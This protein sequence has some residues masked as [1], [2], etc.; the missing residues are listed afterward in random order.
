M[1][2]WHPPVFEAKRPYLQARMAIIKAIRG[3]F[4]QQGLWEVETPALQTSPT[5]DT[6]IHA[7]KTE[8]LN[9]N[10]T[11][12]KT[13]Y[14]HTSPEFAMKKLLVAG[15]GDM[16]QLCHAYRNAEIS[17]LHS[18]EF[19]LLEWYRK[20]ADAYEAVMQ[21]C[22]A[23]IR[24]SASAA[25]AH[26]LRRKDRQTDIGKDFTRLSVADAFWQYAGID[27]T[28][29]LEDA[30]LFAAKA[31][32]AGIRTAPDDRWDDIFFRIMAEKIE[33]FLGDGAPCI[34][35]EYPLSMAALARR[36]PRDKRFAM[37]FEIYACGVELANGFDELTDPAEQ[38]TRFHAEMATKKEIYGFE[39]PVDEDFLKA[40]EHGLPPCAGVAMGVDRLVMLL[41]GAEDIG[42]VLWASVI[43]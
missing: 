43:V 28:A 18:P 13:L 1:N 19:T 15:A 11:A 29:C 31:N 41:T 17:S 21:D 3:Y 27:L 23:L 4:D 34:L 25:G 38:R 7:F 36:E 16:F 22:E 35:H 9:Q 32:A 12:E 5:M 39:Y 37:R 40:I 2:W 10:L 6:H 24:E 33:P 14:L 20:G 30:A 8:L 42:Q 26:V